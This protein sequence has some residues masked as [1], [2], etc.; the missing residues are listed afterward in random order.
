MASSSLNANPFGFTTHVSNPPAGAANVLEMD[1]KGTILA[2]DDNPANLG[3]LSDF[4]H[5]FGFNVLTARNGQAAVERAQYAQPDLILLD[6][7]MPE[8]DGFEACQQLKSDAQTAQIPVIFMTALTDVTNKSQGFALGA[9]DY[10]TKPFQQ[11]EV[12]VRIQCQLK[13]SRLTQQVQ[14]QNEELEKRVTQRTAELQTALKELQSAQVH[15]V[16]SE[17][18][19]SLG[20]LVAGVAHEINNPIN[21]IHG[22]L[23]HIN[24][25]AQSLLQAQSLYAQAMPEPAAAIAA[26]LDALDL[27]FIAEDLPR[28][29]QSMQVGTERIRQIV[30]GLRTF[31]RKD[32]SRRKTIQ[33]VDGI[34]ST[35][36]LLHSR[37][38]G[39]GD[40]P[41]ILIRKDYGELPSI[42]CYASRLNQVWMNLIANAIDALNESDTTVPMITI[43]TQ[44]LSSERVQ[45]QIQDNGRGIPPEH[46]V[47]LFDPFFTTKPVGQGTGLGLAISYSIIV[48]QHQ[49]TLHCES[50][51]GQGTTFTV[52]LPTQLLG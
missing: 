24:D 3:L 38:K 10:I 18:M 39:R 50:L 6:I 25:Y 30:L 31:A 11:E 29:L 42:D 26:E 22:N 21:F 36:M 16:Q 41:E 2:V 28:I 15:L 32:D 14:S 33:L 7:M 19:A 46:Q 20:V 8:M 9:A 17:K 34:E 23:T 4:L 44:A 5:G 52:E 40:R 51:V 1:K 49:G 45:V 48:E 37:T 35:L 43:T 47:R 12:L 13:I 27:D